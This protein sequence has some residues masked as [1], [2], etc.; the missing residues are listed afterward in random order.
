VKLR[1]RQFKEENSFLREKCVLVALQADGGNTLGECDP[2][3]QGDD[4]IVIV[5]GGPLFV[6]RM[7]LKGDWSVS[8]QKRRQSLYRDKYFF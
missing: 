2:L 6:L 8:E 3:S 5:V 1:L 4:G 7:L